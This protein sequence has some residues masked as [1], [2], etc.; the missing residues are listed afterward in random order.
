MR[1]KGMKGYLQYKCQPMV[2]ERRC[3][4]QFSGDIYSDAFNKQHRLAVIN[5]EINIQRSFI[6]QENGNDTF[7]PHI[8]SQLIP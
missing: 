4:L 1:D 7:I 8:F 2:W 5:R 6:N 3:L